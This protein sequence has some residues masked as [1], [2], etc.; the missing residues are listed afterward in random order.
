M[1]GVGRMA[2]YFVRSGNSAVHVAGGKQWS[3]HLH[4]TTHG[5]V[6]LASVVSS[7]NSAPTTSAEPS[8]PR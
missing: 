8:S 2:A 6:G 1:L 3:S 4:V 7:L 5:T